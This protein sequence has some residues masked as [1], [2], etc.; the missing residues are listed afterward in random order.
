MLIL[1]TRANGESRAMSTPVAALRRAAAG[2]PIAYGLRRSLLRRVA[3]VWGGRPG[4]V[5]GARREVSETF[6]LVSAT[7]RAS[8]D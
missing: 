7:L 4:R 5:E 3:D 2:W 8:G 6:H 1:P